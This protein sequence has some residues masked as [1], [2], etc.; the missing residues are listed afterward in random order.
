MWLLD[1]PG[2]EEGGVREDTSGIANEGIVDVVNLLLLMGDEGRTLVNA[3]TSSNI[4][5]ATIKHRSKRIL[6]DITQLQHENL[7]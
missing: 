6:D 4:D 3:I 1:V 7:S 2:K 5:V